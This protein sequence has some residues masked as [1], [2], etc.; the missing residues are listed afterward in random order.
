MA[1]ERCRAIHAHRRRTG[2]TPF[3]RHSAPA[4][5]H[6]RA[7]RVGSEERIMVMA[8]VARCEASQAI[9]TSGWRRGGV[10]RSCGAWSAGFGEAGCEELGGG[11]C[12]W[13]LQL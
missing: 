3:G 11:R 8:C 10:G 5:D 9:R 6:I 12:C 13:G 2:D 7:C 1:G 4:F